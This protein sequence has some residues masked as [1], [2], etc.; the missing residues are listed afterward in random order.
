MAGTVRVT[1]GLGLRLKCRFS[2][3]V[4]VMTTFMVG[5]SLRFG[6]GLVFRLGLGLRFGFGLR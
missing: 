6:F 1:V 3:K 4:S 2:V 5:V